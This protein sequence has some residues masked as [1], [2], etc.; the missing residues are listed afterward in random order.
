VPIGAAAPH[1]RGAPLRVGGQR[2]ASPRQ[3]SLGVRVE[4]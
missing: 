3:I 4:F 2:L 1:H